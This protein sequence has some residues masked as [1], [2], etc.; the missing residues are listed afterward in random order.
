MHRRA[1]ESGDKELWSLYKHLRNEVT[2]K[3]R[4]QRRDFFK[5]RLQEHRGNPKQFW[6]TLRLVLPGKTKV[7]SIEKPVTE[8]ELNSHFVSIAESVLNEAYPG[9]HQCAVAPVQVDTQSDTGFMFEPVTNEDVY[10]A[11]ISLKTS[12]A[13][14]VDE[15]PAKVL[16]AAAGQLAPS[17]ACL[18][19]ESWNSGVFPSYWKIARVSPLHKGGEMNAC[20]NFRPISILPCV[21]KVFEAFTNKQLLKFAIEH[22]LIDKKQFAFKKFSSCNI[23]L[24]LLVDEWKRAID[25]RSMSVAAFLDLRKAFDVINHTLLVNKLAVAGLRG[26]SLQWISNYLEDRKQF[27]SY[28]GRASDLQVIRRGVPQ[29]SVLGPTLFSIYLNGVL[30]TVKHSSCKLFADDT[31]I[32]FTHKDVITAAT[33]VNQDLAHFE[34]W[35]K[36]NEMAAHPGKSN[37]MVFGSRPS[38]KA[39]KDTDIDIYLLNQKL[40]DVDSYK[41]LGVYVDSNLSWEYHLKYICQRVYPKLRML[42][43]IS[44]FLSKDILLLIYKQTILPIMDYGSM[45][46][47]DCSKTVSLKIERLQNQAMRSI[48]N[49]NRKTC[50]QEMRCKLGLLTLANRRRFLRAILTFKIIHNI[51]CPEQLV[52]YLIFRSRMHNRNLR[53]KTLLH[54][55]KVKTQTGQTTFQYSAA[56]DWNSFPKY[57]R[58]ITSL[59]SFKAELYSYFRDLDIKSH[60]CTLN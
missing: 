44:N 9:R 56:A 23:A 55:P 40:K 5:S 8:N 29:G 34:M 20:D 41:Y 12:K 46:W 47:L 4:K 53:D 51:N 21:S 32:H 60:R 22:D 13:T 18:F 31:E 59:Q 2:S 26:T 36:E 33:R 39:V 35:L 43:R 52:D 11:F 10:K 58:D 48:L 57:I 14:G 45:T 28:N 25:E 15:I 1:R 17:V 54:L 3:L 49:T 37:V 24:I 6:K 19:N 42:N 38:L 30:S 16:K 27:V 50:S 7:K